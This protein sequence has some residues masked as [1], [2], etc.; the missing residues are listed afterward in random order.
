MLDPN[1]CAPCRSLRRLNVARNEIG[2]C[3]V[4]ALA[5]GLAGNDCSLADLD[6]TETKAGGEGVSAMAAVLNEGRYRLVK[7]CPVPKSP[8]PFLQ[9]SSPTWEGQWCLDHAP[10]HRAHVLETL[11]P[12]QFLDTLHTQVANMR[13]RQPGRCTEE[14]IKSMI[15]GASRLHRGKQAQPRI[16]HL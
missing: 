14:R 16:V 9:V 4:A 12:T 10:R 7:K 2:D 6:L 1:H 13:Y 11:T 3:G 15:R 8:K 5:A